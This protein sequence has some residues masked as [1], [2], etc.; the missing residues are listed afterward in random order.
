MMSQTAPWTFVYAAD[1]QPGSPRS[2]RFRPVWQENWET[3]QRQIRGLNPEFVLIGGDV[4]R[5]G[6][7]HKWELEDAKADFDALDIPWYAVPGNMDTGNKHTQKQG[8]KSDR[9]DISLNIT[10]DH[11]KNW[12]DVF[13]PWNWSFTHRNLRV[14]GLCDMII[15][16]GLPEEEAQWAWLEEQAKRPHTDHHIWIM[17]SPL[18]IERPDEPQWDIGCAQEYQRW[19]FSIDQPGRARL[20][21]IFKTSGAT[22]VITGHVHCMHDIEAEGIHWDCA[23]AICGTQFTHVW[24]EGKDKI[25]FYE[26][27]VNGPRLSRRFIPLDPVSTRTDSYGPSGHPKP[28]MRDYSLAWEV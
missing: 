28:E 3:A 16:S 14:T 12:Q 22:R 6:S 2:F 9:D 15:N 26:Y 17:H 8:P 10:S 20:L 5:D 27:T 19:Y 18:F 1:M 7:I 4:T 21:D 24:P 25:G 23:P 13:G 11:L